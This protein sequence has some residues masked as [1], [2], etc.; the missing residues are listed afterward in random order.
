MLRSA[1]TQSLTV[2]DNRTNKIYTIPI[3]NNTISALEFKKMVADPR[4]DA[5]PEDESDQGLRYVQC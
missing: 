1:D 5:R 3:V 2:L 4:P